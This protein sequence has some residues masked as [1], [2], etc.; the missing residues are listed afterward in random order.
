[1][2]IIAFI[3]ASV[4]TVC[5][6]VGEA[7]LF[8]SAVFKTLFSSRLKIFHVIDQMRAIGVGS[9][10]IIFLTGSFAGLAL[11][12]QTYIGFHRVGAEEFIGPVV[13]LAMT[14]ELG[15]VLT[16]IMVTGRSGSAMAAEL[17]TMQIT[18]QIDALKTLCIDPFQYLIVPR[19][20]AGALI[21]PFLTIFSMACGVGGGYVFCVYILG[22]SPDTYMSG[23]RELGDIKDITGGLI[24]A[25]FFGLILSWIGCYQGYRTTGGARGVGRATTRSV[26][27]GSII[28]LI[29]NY[30]LS[31][32]L[33]QAGIA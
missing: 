22:L 16:G 8:L 30:F 9:F 20:L 15:P 32:L 7:V 13:G 24:K 25:V 5:V 28:I 6:R 29:A 21:L 17:G 12:L 11:A 10:V 33:F 23:L 18:E 2:K 1:V 26:V 31:S 14:R 19:I 3:G 27:I 4:I